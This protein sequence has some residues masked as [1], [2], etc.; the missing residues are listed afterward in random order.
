MY[1]KVFSILAGLSML[2]GCGGGGGSGSGLSA[3][4][5]G[6]TTQAVVTVSNAKA[7]ST[8]AYS[9][10]QMSSSVSKGTTARVCP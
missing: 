5:S 8:D 2:A 4:Y 10:G 6:A 9:G 3:A 7:L 1:K